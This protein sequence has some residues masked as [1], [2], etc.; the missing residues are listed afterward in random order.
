LTAVV[1]FRGFQSNDGNNSNLGMGSALEGEN[2]ES[3]MDRPLDVSVLTKMPDSTKYQAAR[4]I[5]LSAPNKMR[6]GGRVESPVS[7]KAVDTKPE[8]SRDRSSE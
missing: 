2:E 7:P 8:E 5:E 1:S 6:S 3:A 4:S